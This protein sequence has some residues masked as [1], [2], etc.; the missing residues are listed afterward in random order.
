MQSWRGF[1]ICAAAVAVCACDDDDTSEPA[2]AAVEPMVVATYNG[3]LARGFVPYAEERTGPLS[4]KLGTV[5]VDVLCVQ[6]FWEAADRERLEAAVR[7]NLPHAYSIAPVPGDCGGE[8][9]CPAEEADPL[10]MCAREMCGDEPDDNLVTCTI[11]NCGEQVNA[12]SDACTSCIGGQV[13][14]SLDDIL[15]VCGPAAEHRPCYAYGGSVGTAI[16]SRYDM[17]A[18]DSIAFDSALNRRAAL[19]AHLTGTPRGDVHVF[20]THLTSKLTNIPYP[21]G[22]CADDPSMTCSAGSFEAEQLNE[23]N[24]LRDWIDEKAGQ[25]QVVVMGDFNTGPAVD[26]ATAEIPENYNALVEGFDRTYAAQDD[27]T[28]TFCGGANPLIVG[29]D[30]EHQVL[31]DHVLLRGFTGI[32]THGVRFLTEPV[33]LDGIDTPQ[34]YSDH[35]GVQVTIE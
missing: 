24:E 6:E 5:D 29:D 10:A 21:G 9:A 3:G 20:C 34:A 27:A 18:T 16:L 19:Y 13:G 23:I 2:D 33:T 25:G 15:A 14:N 1:L 30:V 28:C 11:T 26:G 12:L 22:R 4:E 8:V 31:L 17:A 7:G 35:F 32:T